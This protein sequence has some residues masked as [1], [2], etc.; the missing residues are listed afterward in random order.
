LAL[1][2]AIVAP[3][4]FAAGCAQGAGDRCQVQSDCATG[5]TCVLPAGATPQAG[6]TCE[7]TG[8]AGVIISDLSTV[9]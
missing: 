1:T 6:G 4:A 8:D 5:L 3:L 9:G 2:L 7:A